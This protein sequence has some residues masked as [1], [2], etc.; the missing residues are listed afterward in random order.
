MK[1]IFVLVAALATLSAGCTP[2][3]QPAGFPQES[4]W[5]Q[6]NIQHGL[7][8]G[9]TLVKLAVDAGVGYQN[10]LNA[11]PGIDPWLPPEGH[12]VLLPYATLPPERL[13]RGITINLAEYRL[14][15]WADNDAPR[16]Y[17]VGI[18]EEQATTPEGD[19]VILNKISNPV[20]KV[21]KAVRRERRLPASLPPGP[22]NP[23]GEFWLGFSKAG[24]GIHGTN[25]PFGIGRRAS[26][27]CIRLYAQDIRDLFGR[28]QVGTPVR[29]LYQPIK[30][31]IADGELLMETH[32][33]FLGR[34]ADPRQELQRRLAALDWQGEL[35]QEAVVRGLQEARGVPVR[36]SPPPAT[37]PPRPSRWSWRPAPDERLE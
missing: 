3:R 8:A 20:W 25:D 10:L 19:F 14:F 18:A 34:I 21:P 22:D 24:H 4:T 16:F 36:I 37:P 29:I 26:R 17:P 9:E 5:A 12:A 1:H 28:V 6:A 32:P 15:Y 30:V 13:Q 7:V 23:L 35:D 11:N 31:A 33:D 2:G 27:G